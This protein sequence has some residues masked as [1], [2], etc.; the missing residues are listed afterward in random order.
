MGEES[1]GWIY[2]TRDKVHWLAL[3][4]TVMNRLIPQN[5]WNFWN[6]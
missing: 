4:V 1:V 3:V 6:S 5:A 2:S